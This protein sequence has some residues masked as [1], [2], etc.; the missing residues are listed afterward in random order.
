LGSAFDLHDE[1]FRGKIEA[2]A[3]MAL[4]VGDVE[5]LKRE[6]EKRIL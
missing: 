1:P 5:A 6:R 3:P 2:D 4:A